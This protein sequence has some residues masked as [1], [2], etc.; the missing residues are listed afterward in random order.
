MSIANVYTICFVSRNPNLS[1]RLLIDHFYSKDCFWGVNYKDGLRSS[2]YQYD[3]GVK[4]QG[5]MY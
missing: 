5:K 2:I 4:W 3:L 1:F